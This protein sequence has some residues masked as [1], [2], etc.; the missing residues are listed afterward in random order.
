M[1]ADPY[2]LLRVRVITE[3]EREQYQGSVGEPW[4]CSHSTPWRPPPDDCGGLAE[5]RIGDSH[6]AGRVLCRECARVVAE[7]L[8]ACVDLLDAGEISGWLKQREAPK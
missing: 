4:F 6:D 5:V 2:W 1:R 8:L 3:T 7:R